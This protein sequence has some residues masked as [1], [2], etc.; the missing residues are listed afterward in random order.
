M[1]YQGTINGRMSR[2][3]SYVGSPARSYEERS[4]HLHQLHP[5][6]G[7]PVADPVQ[8]PLHGGGQP[9]APVLQQSGAVQPALCPY[10]SYREGQMAA[11][12]AW[13]DAKMKVVDACPD[14]TR[15][16]DSVMPCSS[17]VAELLR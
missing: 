1:S 8:A 17:H 2:H 15:V 16:Q 11:A 5:A 4:K 10:R 6:G 9:A 14:C 7:L 13:F 3:G 12:A